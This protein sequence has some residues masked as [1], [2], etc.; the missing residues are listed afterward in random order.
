MN[1]DTF[2]GRAKQLRG[3]IEIWLG[4]KLNEPQVE[5]M[6]NTHKITGWLQE[7]KGLA[8]EDAE[9]EVK[10]LQKSIKQLEEKWE[11]VKKDP[12]AEWQSLEESVNSKIR[13]FMSRYS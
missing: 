4:K 13:A 11:H 3:D 5:L 8:K 1:K 12:G 6:G 9:R 2:E 7:K 10:E